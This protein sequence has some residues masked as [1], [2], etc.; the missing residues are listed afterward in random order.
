MRQIR[1]T[2]RRLRSSCVP[3]GYERGV[4]RPE[5]AKRIAAALAGD[6]DHYWSA[7]SSVTD[8]PIDVVDM[9][10]GCG[11]MSAGFRALNGLVPA[12]RLAGAVDI[13]RISNESYEANL[14]I[15][16][17]TADI[18]ELAAYD[19]LPSEAMPRRRAKA[20]LILI[21]CAPCQGFSSY[22]NGAKDR[23]NPLFVDFAIIASR[24]SPDVIVV[25]NV[26]ELLTDRYWGLVEDALARFE[27]SGYYVHLN[28]HNMAEFGLPQERFRAV[29]VAMR[30]S[31][32]MPQSG[33]LRRPQ[34]RTVRSAIADLPRVSAGE[35][36]E[37]DRIHYSAKHRESTLRTISR[38]SE[39]RWEPSPRCGS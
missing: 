17:L 38:G 25:E 4:P 3:P 8:G 39:E 34:F 15:A 29:M 14:G 27:R 9:F 16:P 20:P 13:D 5:C 24:L 7:A 32:R 33:F 10:S 26:P 23:R 22:R 18:S 35:R 6:I 2:W 37:D 11:G 21:G 19:R 30:H 36:A 28:V 31:F 12:F 1:A